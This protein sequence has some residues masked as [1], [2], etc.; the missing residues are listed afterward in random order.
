MKVLLV[1]A[2]KETR[3][4]K[5]QFSDFIDAVSKVF[6]IQHFEKFNNIFK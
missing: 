2:H 5:V 4:G 1:N 3:S 6:Y